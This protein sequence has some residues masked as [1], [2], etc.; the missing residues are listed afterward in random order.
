MVL[1]GL[2]IQSGAAHAQTPAN[3][4]LDEF[5]SMRFTPANGPG[6]YLMV[7]GALVGGHLVPSVGLTLDYAHHPFTLFNATCAADDAENCEVTTVN[8]HLVE[9]TFAG[10]LQFALSLFERVQLGLTVPLAYTSGEA[11]TFT[12]METGEFIAIQGGN[13]FGLGDPRLSV[14]VRIAGRGTE[15]P[16]VSA[17]VYG[18]APIGQ[19]TAEDR[20]L[21]DDTPIVGGHVIGEFI[22]KGFHVAGNV[23]GFFRPQQT[24]FS[25]EVG[26]ML[27]YGLGIGYEITPLI[28]VLG[29]VEGASSLGLSLDENPLEARIAGRLTQGDF[30]FTVGGGMGVVSGVGVPLF[31]VLGAAQWAPIRTDQDGDGLVDESDDCPAE[32]EDPDGYFDTDGCPEADNDD[33]GLLDANDPCPDSGEDPDEFEDD[34]GCP[35]P[36]NDGDGVN[37]GYDSCPAA[38]EDM[39]NDRDDDGCPDNDRDRDGVEDDNDACPDAAEDTDGFG[40]LDGCPEADFDGDTVPD[41]GDE[42]PDVPE[43]VNGINDQDGCPEEDADS[44][45]I[46]DDRDRCPD[47]PETLNGRADEDGCP[48]GDALVEVQG[49]EIRLLQQVQFATNSARIRGRQSRQILDAVEFILSRNPQYRRV[50]VEGHTDNVGQP[51]SNMRL[52]QERAQAC[53]DYLVR[54]GIPAERLY[55]QG[56]GQDRPIADN[57]SNDGR[58]RNR[59]V[60]FHIEAPPPEAPP[61]PPAEDVPAEDPAP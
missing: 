16:T 61:A 23:G 21:G 12:R 52:S 6:N 22:A 39:D 19:L 50:R 49:T 54:A 8:V 10:H 60:E 48:D 40:D 30:T 31:R 33:D 18:T 3:V 44:D 41:D 26:S 59:R 17:S 58:E 9:L 56:F 53:V 35:D 14:K 55:A 7:E 46:V 43:I 42:C 4:P 25:T 2:A 45:G 32:P 47:R 1:V 13:S 34:D 28:M 15:G 51:E 36:D 11:F 27:T 37:D 20:Y 57:S 29:E 38:R 5:S 24:L